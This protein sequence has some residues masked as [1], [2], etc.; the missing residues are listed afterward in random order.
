[1]RGR[2]AVFSAAALAILAGVACGGD[3]LG[4]KADP[5]DIVVPAAT[6]N[7]VLASTSATSSPERPGCGSLDT[8]LR[9]RPD[10]E[11]KNTLHLIARSAVASFEREQAPTVSGALPPVDHQLCESAEPFPAKIPTC[12][13]A[14]LPSGLFQARSSGGT[15]VSG[16]RC[17][18]FA[19]EGQVSARFGYVKGGPYR[20]PAFG[21]PDPGRE[22]FEAWAEEDLDGDGR[23]KLY[24][25][26]GKPEGG[27]LRI[28]TSV[29]VSDAD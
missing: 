25:L 2:I 19:L 3:A 5:L 24:T 7:E 27:S 8:M 4:K 20:G 16:W 29:F 14:T 9:K 1:M 21:G 28:A 23:T 13:P 22:G 17:L 11:I 12:G 6:S 26:T 15:E 18:K 10:A